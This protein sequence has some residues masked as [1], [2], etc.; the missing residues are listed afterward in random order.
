MSLQT[1]LR[2]LLLSLAVAPGAAC[3]TTDERR[4]DEVISAMQ[5]GRYS[6]ALGRAKRLAEAHPD[7]AVA[8]RLYREAEL[9]FILDQGRDQVFAGELDAGLAFFEQARELAPEDPTVASW[10]LKTRYQLALHWL[11]VATELKG[12]ERLKEAE[13]AYEMVLEYDPD[14]AAGVDGLSHVLL[15]ENYRSGM[16]K[17]YFDDGL[18]SFRDL[19]LQRARRDF[20]VSRRYQ[21]NEPAKK[22]ADQVEE[23]LAEERLAQARELE[24]TGMYFAARNEYR[25]VLLI[26]PNNVEGRAGIDRMDRESRATRTMAEAEMALRRGELDKADKSVDEA[27]VLTAAQQDDASLLQSSIEEKRL[28]DRYQSARSLAEDYRYP[29]SVQAFTELLAIAP[30]Y[31]DAAMR[32]TTL[33]EFI[34][35]AEEFYAKALATSDDAVAEEYLRAIHPVIWPEYK[36]VVERLKAIEARKAAKA[37]KDGKATEGA[38]ETGEEKPDGPGGGG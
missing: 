23:M 28:E 12:P 15:L 31:K 27:Q 6:E 17:T 4:E 19:E 24:E 20:Q 22:R 37:E 30:D 34:R 25:L 26:D 32:K 36:D 35:L 3:Q 8:P 13:H 11:D 38:G 18:S 10:I 2:L 16:S 5:H 33:E 1:R 9:A 21:D 7:D 14:S 29:E